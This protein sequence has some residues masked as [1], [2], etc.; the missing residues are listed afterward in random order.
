MTSDERVDWETRQN[1]KIAAKYLPK[2]IP[3]YVLHRRTASSVYSVLRKIEDIPFEQ[4]E[5]ELFVFCEE[6]EFKEFAYK[7]QRVLEISSL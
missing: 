5:M 3:A 7:Y 4:L 6:P 1:K 2:G